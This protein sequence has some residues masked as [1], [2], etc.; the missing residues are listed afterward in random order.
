MHGAS[1][2]KALKQ[3]EHEVRPSS[4]ILETE[5]LDCVPR[6]GTATVAAAAEHFRGAR[7]GPAYLLA[8]RAWCAGAP[9]PPLLV[10]EVGRISWNVCEEAVRLVVNGSKLQMI[11]GRG[12]GVPSPGVGLTVTLLVN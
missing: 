1:S 5:G 2:A 3:D 4:Y 7:N 8:P 12:G 6:I 11:G 9:R 10:C